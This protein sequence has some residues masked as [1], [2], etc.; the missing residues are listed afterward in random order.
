[1]SLR[2]RPLFISGWAFAITAAT[3]RLLFCAA[4]ADDGDP[5]AASAGTAGAAATA[6]TDGGA[7]GKGLPACDAGEAILCTLTG[8]PAGVELKAVI[9][10]A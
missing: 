5:S 8:G 6:D 10:E 7:A 3:S 9:C 4:A 1:M 2:Y